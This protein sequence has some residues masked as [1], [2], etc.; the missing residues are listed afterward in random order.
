MGCF[1]QTLGW[2]NASQWKDYNHLLGEKYNLFPQASWALWEQESLVLKAGSMLR[3]MEECTMDGSELDSS[4]ASLVPSAVQQH[5]VLLCGQGP[6]VGFCLRLWMWKHFVNHS[7]TTW[8]W[9]IVKRSKL[10]ALASWKEVFSLR[11]WS[12]VFNMC[13]FI[14]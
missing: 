7:I 1:W 10:K 13:P 2:G 6:A 14:V 5:P 9:A 12:Y 4:P 3:R 8:M 11:C